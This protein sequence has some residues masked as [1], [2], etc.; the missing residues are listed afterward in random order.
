M[1]SSCRMLLPGPQG[2]LNW[3]GGGAILTTPVTSGPAAAGSLRCESLP[4]GFM[5][6][7]VR[8]RT[9]PPLLP[10][11][12]VNHEYGERSPREL[13][14]LPPQ[15]WFLPLCFCG[16]VSLWIVFS[17]PRVPETGTSSSWVTVLR[18]YRVPG[19][20]ALCENFYIWVHEVYWS[21]LSSEM[22]MGYQANTDFK[23]E[24]KSPPPYLLPVCVQSMLYLPSLFDAVQQL[25]S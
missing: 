21:V 19:A 18:C 20:N 1:S 25:N 4:E 5:M 23:K 6:Y 7:Q 3:K 24:L 17:Q 10:C 9:P 22:F 2:R 14:V 8:L 15:R 11:R 12:E 16:E 13:L